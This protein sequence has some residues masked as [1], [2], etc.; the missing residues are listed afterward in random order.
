MKGKIHV[1]DVVYPV[2]SYTN[3]SLTQIKQ[4]FFY[5]DSKQK[6]QVMGNDTIVID[7]GYLQA[8]LDMKWARKDFM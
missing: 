8:T 7:G 1:V 2:N 5:V 6:A 4:S 3:F